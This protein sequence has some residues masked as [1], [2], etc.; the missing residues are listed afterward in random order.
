MFVR[1]SNDLPRNINLYTKLRKMG[2]GDSIVAL[3]SE[4]PCDGLTVKL[5]ETLDFLVPG[6]WHNTT[7]I[8]TMIQREVGESHPGR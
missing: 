6:Q 8:T 1:H 7:D 3:L 4:L 2:E 5:L